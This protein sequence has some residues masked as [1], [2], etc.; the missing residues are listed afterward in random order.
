M[1]ADLAEDSE[2][3][4]DL[5]AVAAD[6]ADRITIITDRIFTAVGFLARVV[7]ITEAE[8]VLADFWV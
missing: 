7:I 5:A 8:A 4:A 1:A 6:S 3:V 2:A